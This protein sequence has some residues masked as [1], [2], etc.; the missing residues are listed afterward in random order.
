MKLRHKSNLFVTLLGVGMLVVITGISM[1]SFRHF[2]LQTA[3]HQAQKTAEI[4]RTFLTEAMAAGTMFDDEHREQLLS[5]IAQTPGF[6]QLRIVRNSNLGQEPFSAAPI[7]SQQPDAIEQQVLASARAQTILSGN[8][9]PSLRV[10]IPYIAHNNGTPNCME[11]H[12]VPEGTVLGVITLETDLSSMQAEALTANA[13]LIAATLF[14]LLL[15]AW[16]IQRGVTPMIHTAESVQTVLFRAEAGDFSSRSPVLSDDE[17]GSIAQGVNHLM[18]ELD[19]NIGRIEQQI[20]SLT[21]EG[22]AEGGDQLAG[23]VA[24][25]DQLVEAQRFKRA[26]EEDEDLPEV[27]RRLHEMLER[28]FDFSRFSIYEVDNVRGRIHPVSVNG[29]T[30]LW[31]D[32]AILT[33]P[34]SCRARRTGHTVENL[35]I[36]HMCRSFAP[37][38]DCDE[39]LYHVCLPMILSGAVG[40]VIQLVFPESE[41]EIVQRYV[42]FLKVYLR[43]AAPVIETKRLMAG[44]KETT[45]RD[46]MTGLHNRRSLE[47]YL[48]TLTAGIKRRGTQLGVLMC[49]VDFFKQVN[50]Q[51]GHEVGDV[52]LKELAKILTESVRASDLVVRYGGE[53]F[54]VLLQDSNAENSVMVA[55]KIRSKLEEHVMRAGTTT[56]KKTLSIGVAE[57]PGD[58]DAF[59]QAVKYADVALYQAKEGGRNRVVRFTPEMWPEGDY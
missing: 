33:T 48:D 50:D 25:V 22:H 3:E 4:I 13:G 34:Q 43:E 21:G 37:G 51:H 54:V 15:A 49:D 32:R 7:V 1:Y 24:L 8:L 30:E 20:V 39:T 41:K 12:D 16:I 38:K 52:V 9:S 56:L 58:T 59:W 11:C 47:E 42:P 23:T 35:E 2:S 40:G 53:E 36:P 27:Y 18:E 31:C 17:T 55:E 44:L 5:R 6:S 45:L 26:I 28:D 14:F 29:C 19:Q 46:P 10:S 57:Y